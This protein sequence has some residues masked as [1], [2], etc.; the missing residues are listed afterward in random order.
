MV[1]CVCAMTVCPCFVCLYS[2]LLVR[3][4]S[5][6]SSRFVYAVVSRP[7]HYLLWSRVTMRSGRTAA[8]Q[9][10]AQCGRHP[11]FGCTWRTHLPDRFDSCSVNDRSASSTCVMSACEVWLFCARFMASSKTCEVAKGE[12]IWQSALVRRPRR[13][14]MPHGRPCICVVSG[15][16]SVIECGLSRRA[17]RLRHPD[18]S[19]LAAYRSSGRVPMA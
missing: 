15:R 17:V 13:H 3:T 7:H 5:R 18:R 4:V 10:T 11:C 6:R 12:L 9:Q 2:L 16:R 14:R 1:C 8:V 19:W